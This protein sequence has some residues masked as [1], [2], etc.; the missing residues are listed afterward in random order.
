[1]GIIKVVDI[2]KIAYEA[3]RAYNQQILGDFS[4]KPWDNASQN[5]MD[6]VIR[7]VQFCIEN[8]NAPA[9][10][11]HDRWL[12]G[13][14]LAGWKHAEFTDP[15]QK[16]HNKIMPWS[17]LSITERNRDRLFVKIVDCLLTSL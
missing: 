1:M 5:T 6:E 4:Q 3:L 9:S 11:M 13:L 15:A 7:N 8:P 2:A 16:V 14:L 10:S 17:M 12:N